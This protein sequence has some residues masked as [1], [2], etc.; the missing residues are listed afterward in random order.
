MT[1]EVSGLPP[2]ERDI[3]MVFQSYA[4]YPHMSVRDNLGVRL[5]VRHEP[6]EAMQQKVPER[7]G[8]SGS[9]SCWI[10]S[11]GSSPADSASAWLLVARWCANH[12][13]F[14]WTNPSRISMPNSGFRCAPS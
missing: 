9:K 8:C 13:S 10:A 6:R 2:G 5:K 12:G 4:L 3:A 14:S 11:R 1:E 7:P